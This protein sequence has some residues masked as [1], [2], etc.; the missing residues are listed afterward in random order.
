MSVRSAARSRRVQCQAFVRRR[1]SFAASSCGSRP[2][3]RRAEE[4]QVV[5]G[6]RDFG[7]GRAQMRGEDVR[8]VRVEDRGLHRL[9][10]EGL[11]VVDEEGVQRVVAGDQ[12]RQRALPGAS[13]A[14]RLLPQGGPGARVAGDDDGVQAGDV[15]AEFEGGGGGEAEEFA[16][17][18]GAFEGA[19]FLGEVAA[20]VGGHA[21][22]QG[23][24]DLGEA[25]L[26]DHRDQLGAAPGAYEGDRAHA[27]DGQVGEEVGGLG[28]GGAADGGAL[29]AVQFGERGFPEG[30]DQF[31]AWGGVV[32]DLD[33]RE[34]GQAACGDRGLGGGRGGQQEDGRGAVAGAQAAQAAQ[35]LGDVGAEDAAVGVAL[36]DDDVAQGTQEGGPAGVGG[37]YPAVQHVGVGQ[38]VVGVLAYPLAFLEGGVPVVHRGAY[39]VAQRL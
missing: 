25:F 30:E 4:L 39:G 38:D 3:G 17:V 19:A 33:H 37:Q 11:G 36:V 1:S 35:D 20:A 9:V 24:V 6:E 34:A 23:A 18:E 31:A 14:A 22:G 26:G 21:P 8:V 32:G 7:G 5:V 29:L 28:G 27:L 13:G 15:D 2:G 12:D 16:G 10:E